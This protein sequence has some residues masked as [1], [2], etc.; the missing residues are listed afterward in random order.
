LEKAKEEMTLKLW[1]SKRL[2]D[3]I[4]HPVTGEKMY[5]AGRMSAFVPVNFPVLVGM[6]LHGPNSKLAAMFWQ[7]MNQSVNVFCNYVNRSGSEVDWD[8]MIKCYVGACSTSVAMAMT[9]MTL[10]ETF[11]VL[12]V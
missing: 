6:L 1:N 7:W 8:L 12:A 9:G 11:P 3:A 2:V 10:L 4:I 5:W